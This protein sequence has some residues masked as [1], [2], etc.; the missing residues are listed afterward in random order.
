MNWPGLLRGS[1]VGVDFEGRFIRAAQAVSGRHGAWRPS[2]AVILP[3]AV[4]GPALDRRDA[5]QLAGAL[6]RQGFRGNRLVVGV[7][8]ET[9]AV[10]IL[11]LPPRASGAPLEEIARTQLA[12]MHGYDPQAAETACWDLPSSS[13]PK[14]QTQAMAVAC[15]HADAEAILSAFED[16]GLSVVALDSR[17]HAIVRAC[18]PHLS[19]SGITAVLDLEWDQAVLLLVYKDTAIYRRT[20]P[21]AAFKQLS[22]A[23]G[24]KLGLEGDAIDCLLAEVG[25]SPRADEDPS[26]GAAVVPVLRKYLGGLAAAVKPPF[27]YVENQYPGAEVDRLLLVGEGA[28]VPGIAGVLQSDLGVSVRPAAPADAAG[29]P[30]ALEAKSRDPS[31]VAAFGLA[32]YSDI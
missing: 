1:H 17:L 9:M 6:V 2:A 8:D 11:D 5:E 27:T 29:C 21:E 12:S 7:P 13:R 22:Q 10:G 26:Y 16:S 19:A 31:L 24:Q 4:P 23:L 30:A 3:R 15:R 18:R 20:M 32:L 25:L 28:A 14:A